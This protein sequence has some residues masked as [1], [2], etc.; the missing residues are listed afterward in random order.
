MI[1]NKINIFHITLM[2]LVFGSGVAYL[3]MP[4]HRQHIKMVQRYV[5]LILIAMLI[6]SPFFWLVSA[7]FKDADV[8]MQYS[9]LPPPSE[10]SSKTLNLKNFY[11][12][13]TE[14]LDSLFE[15]ENT[16]RGEVHFWR[17]LLNL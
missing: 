1:V 16:I 9:F 4:R 5:I 6:L 12:P 7:V 8:L 17:Y 2:F 3:L 13:S 15:A 11:N 14:E 10:W